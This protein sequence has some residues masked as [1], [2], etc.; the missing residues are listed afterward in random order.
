M[1]PYLSTAWT[2]VASYTDDSMSHTLTT[3]TDAILS[4]TS[5]SFRLAAV[6]DYGISQFSEQLSSAIA[7]LPS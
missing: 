4:Y 1:S 5:Y 6:N 3:T 2:N 7:P